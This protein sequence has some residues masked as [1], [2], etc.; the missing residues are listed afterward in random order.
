M[1]VSLYFSET[2]WYQLGKSYSNHHEW[3]YFIVSLDEHFEK[4][5][6]KGGQSYQSVICHERAHGLSSCRHVANV[7]VGHCTSWTHR[8]QNLVKRLPSIWQWS[9]WWIRLQKALHILFRLYVLI[10]DPFNRYQTNWSG[11]LFALL[12]RG[13]E[14][15]RE[16]N[17]SIEY[18]HSSSFSKV[19]GWNATHCSLN[20]MESQE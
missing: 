13:T 12:C 17:V 7:H 8:V 11:G 18:A 2:S 1:Q 10:T 14:L 16:P 4:Y 9:W 6:W 20:W 15:K 3:S 19:G 5:Q